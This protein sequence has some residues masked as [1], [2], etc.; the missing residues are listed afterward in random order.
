MITTH[1]TLDAILNTYRE[2]IGVDFIGYRN[3]CYRVL[4]I[5]QAL[6]LLYDVKVDLEQAAIALAFHDLGIWTDHTVDYLPPSIR[7]AKAYLATRPEI[8]EMQTI[9]MISQ[10][11]KI[12]TFMFD[13][14]VELFRQADLVDFSLGMVRNGLDKTFI[15][16]IKEAF[17]NAGFHK[18]LLQL[19]VMNVIKH[20][21]KPAPMMKW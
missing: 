11:H 6:G 3:H 17:P 2:Q 14:E 1:P 9:L 21:L 20:P 5:Y 7:E 12:R 16:T 13:T 19:G 18:R 8:D 15:R 10:H 4:N